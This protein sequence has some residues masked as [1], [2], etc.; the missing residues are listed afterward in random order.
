MKEDL[1]QIPC[2]AEPFKGMAN[3][4]IRLVFDSQENQT[5]EVLGKIASLTGKFGWLCFL[6]GK[7][8]IQPEQVVNL[9]ALTPEDA[10]K[11]P[12]QRMRGV[13]YRLWEQKGSQGDFETYYRTKMEALI[14]QIKEK[15]A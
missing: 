14:N 13:L 1:L 5:D 8:N 9:P 12:A 11:S 3:R 6:P 15:L 7:E 2:T 10:G 4:A